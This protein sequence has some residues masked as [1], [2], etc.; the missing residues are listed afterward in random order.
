MYKYVNKNI[1]DGI[2][3]SMF[4]GSLKMT[5][6]FLQLFWVERYKK[7]TSKKKIDEKS[8]SLP[9]LEMLQ[10]KRKGVR[11]DGLSSNI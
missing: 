10:D 8:E 3:K 7:G 1:E 9:I 5:A 2:A 11:D 4:D 6:T